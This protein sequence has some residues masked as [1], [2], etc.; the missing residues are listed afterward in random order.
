M[1]T[2][3]ELLKKQSACKPGFGRQLAFFGVSKENKDQRIPI[4]VVALIGNH[5]DYE[6]AVQNSMII[7]RQ[8]FDILF[9]RTMFDMWEFLI[10][11]NNLYDKDRITNQQVATEWLRRV[12][13]AT[14]AQEAKA[15]IEEAK[16]VSFGVSSHVFEHVLQW[17]GW[18]Q[19]SLY[20]STLG[21]AANSRVYLPVR[22][23]GR[24]VEKKRPTLAEK[25]RAASSARALQ[26][27]GRIIIDVESRYPFDCINGDMTSG[28]R[29]AT[30][31]KPDSTFDFLAT[32]KFRESQAGIITR[33][34]GG[35]FVIR[36]QSPRHAFHL[37]SSALHAS[38]KTLTELRN[39]VEEDAEEWDEPS[40]QVRARRRSASTASGSDESASDSGSDN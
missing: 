23:N 26:S 35:G 32:M 24:T 19:P 38:D 28:E 33:D 4:H 3:L 12:Q 16:Y 14:N 5:E 13:L 9:E 39:Q 8:E 17:K 31:L 11:S 21:D 30:V 20:L 37:F 40:V 18:T 36:V 2:S 10:G 22:N 1:Y 6:W 7:D 15:L 25:R 27:S 29:V 34:A